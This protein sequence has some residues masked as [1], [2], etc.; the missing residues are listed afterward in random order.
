MVKL[1]VQRRAQS[2]VVEGPWELSRT[3]SDPVIRCAGPLRLFESSFQCLWCVLDSFSL[4]VERTH[5]RP[6]LTALVARG[7]V[8]LDEYQAPGGR[9]F[10]QGTSPLGLIPRRHPNHLSQRPKPSYQRYLQTTANSPMS[11]TNTYFT[12]SPKAGSSTSA[13]QTTQPDGKHAK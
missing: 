7:S 11:G 1:Q 12:T 2:D 10:T 4:H 6:Q 9:D 5:T 13:W 8:V 3:A